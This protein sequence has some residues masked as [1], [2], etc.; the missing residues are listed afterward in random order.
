MNCCRNNCTCAAIIL[1][2]IVGV[3]LGVLYGFGLVPTG[4]IFWAYLAV[5]LLGALLAPL[6]SSSS[7]SKESRNCFCS[8]SGLFFTGV[9]G[10]IISA[11]VGLIVAPVAAVVAVAIVLGVATLFTVIELVALVCVARC[12]CN[13]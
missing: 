3:V 6:Y 9:I 5:G 12:N 2:I 11:I 10:T 8:L 1:G 4:I 13:N 7:C